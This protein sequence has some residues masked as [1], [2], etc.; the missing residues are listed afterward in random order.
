MEKDTKGRPRLRVS[1]ASGQEYCHYF[2]QP[3]KECKL[4]CPHGCLH[5]KLPERLRQQALRRQGFKGNDFSPVEAGKDSITVEK[6]MLYVSFHEYDKREIHYIRKIR[7]YVDGNGGGDG[8]QQLFGVIYKTKSGGLSPTSMLPG[9]VSSPVEIERGRHAGWVDLPFAT[10]IVLKPNEDPD[11]PI[12]SRGLWLGVF[13]AQGGSIVRMFGHRCRPD[14]RNLSAGDQFHAA[15]AP[16]EFPTS[17]VVPFRGSMYAETSGLWSR[18]L[19]IVLDSCRLRIRTNHLSLSMLTESD[20]R[21]R[22]EEDEAREKETFHFLLGKEGDGDGDGNGN[23]NGDNATRGSRLSEVS[24][25]KVSGGDG[26]AT[27]FS[28]SGVD[29]SSGGWA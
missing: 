26:S 11:V 10:P 5:E 20:N 12:E 2:Q 3:G 23:G 28:S 17:T 1:S 8:M 18:L 16:G 14:N 27:D 4:P 29:S 24:V 21:R 13:A 19:A 22:Q 15:E 25:G 6:P 7:I 9:A